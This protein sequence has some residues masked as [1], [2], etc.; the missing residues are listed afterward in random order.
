MCGLPVGIIHVSLLLRRVAKRTNRLDEEEEEEEVRSRSNSNACRIKRRL[1][2]DYTQCI[3]G[4]LFT[5]TDGDYIN[6]RF[7]NNLKASSFFY[8]SPRTAIGKV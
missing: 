3:V 7:S 4:R 8:F 5:P 2:T 1:H 6:S